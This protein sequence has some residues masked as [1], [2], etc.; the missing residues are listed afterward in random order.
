M[1]LLREFGIV[2]L[3]LGVFLFITM[4]LPA[5]CVWGLTR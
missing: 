4:A 2:T 5:A 1:S 3:K